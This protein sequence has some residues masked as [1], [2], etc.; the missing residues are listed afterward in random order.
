MV[1]GPD[2]A[3]IGPAAAVAT[4]LDYTF[5][6]DPFVLKGC[7]RALP[8]S[9][10]TPVLGNHRR[11]RSA[12]VG[13]FRRGCAARRRVLGAAVLATASGLPERPW[14]CGSMSPT[15]CS[16]PSAPTRSRCS[17]SYPAAAT[18]APLPASEASFVVMP[19]DSKGEPAATSTGLGTGSARCP[20]TSGSGTNTGDATTAGP[21]Q[22]PD[23]RRLLLRR[24][25]AVATRLGGC[26]AARAAAS[27]SAGLSDYAL[28]AGVFFYYGL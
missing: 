5:A 21:T 16:A 11:R 3:V 24:L 23:T 20:G 28:W 9:T 6:E 25:S 17:P 10:L 14:R 19:C 27:A 26:P 8:G 13:G 15:R 1:D 18:T 7:A 2:L 4:K 22:A 12:H